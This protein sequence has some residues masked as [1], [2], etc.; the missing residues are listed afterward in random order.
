MCLPLIK[1]FKVDGTV[2]FV[3]FSEK[4]DDICP[5]IEN[6]VRGEVVI[7]GYVLKPVSGGTQC[8]YMVQSDLKGSIPTSIVSMVSSNQPMVLLHIKKHLE[9]SH[10]AV[11][12]SGAIFSGIK[13]YTYEDFQA[14]IGISSTGNSSSSNESNPAV[15]GSSGAAASNL[16]LNS[17]NT[18]L[19]SSSN[20][21]LNSVTSNDIEVI[22]NRMV[23]I[24]L[25]YSISYY[26]MYIYLLY[27]IIFFFSLPQNRNK[28]QTSNHSYI[29]FFPLLL[30]YIASPHYRAVGFIFGLIVA[31]RFLL[32]KVVFPILFKNIFYC[33]IHLFIM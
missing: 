19:P 18:S 2:I 26:S 13:K 11:V 1:K 30:Y 10:A 20:Q 9:T 14:K 21:P 33:I 4:F 12:K 25:S 15:G 8:T 24:Y 27:T 3:A 5:L 29:L 28:K 31:V 17:N 7:A 23:S 16:N 32:K 6:H 22:N